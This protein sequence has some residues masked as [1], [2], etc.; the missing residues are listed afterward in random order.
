M[1]VHAFYARR[2]IH[3]RLGYGL[4]F[5]VVNTAGNLVLAGSMGARGIALA[6]TLAAAAASVY[7]LVQLRR[8]MAASVDRFFAV[9]WKSA[10]T[11]A[12]LAVLV[13]VVDRMVPGPVVV[14]LAAAAAVAAGA[15]M[16]LVHS[17][18]IEGAVYMWDLL[19]MARAK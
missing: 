2:E 9:L 8:R 19:R 13:V 10:L 12:V 6:H 5:L 14:R 1:V 11:A 18:R 4:V 7:Q 17:L 3:V 15:F 16:A